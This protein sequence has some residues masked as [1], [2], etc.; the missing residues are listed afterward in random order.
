MVNATCLHLTFTTRHLARSRGKLLDGKEQHV[1]WR[2]VAADFVT[3]ESG[4]G[5]V[6]QAPAFGEVDYEVLIAEQSRFE[7]GQ[8]PE[9]I[10]A[11]GADGK[12]TAD[13]P[14]FV[15]R[16]VKDADKDII[17]EL[18]SRELLFFQEQYLHDYPFCW[19]ADQD[20]LIQY[21]RRSWFIRTTKFKEKL[22][23]KQSRN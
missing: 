16:W 15:G 4:S 7:K 14:D 19:R 21:P 12:F 23:A 9:L 11:V 6:H 22:L 3:T 8:G 10:C 20:P 13:A 17:R 18:K 5:L 2:V 1:A